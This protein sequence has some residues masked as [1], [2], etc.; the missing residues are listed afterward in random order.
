MYYAFATYLT[1][2]FLISLV[3]NVMI[4]CF[5][6]GEGR[7]ALHWLSFPPLTHELCLQEIL[8]VTGNHKEFE[9]II[10]SLHRYCAYTKGSMIRKFLLI[11]YNCNML[12][13][14]CAKLCSSWLQAYT[15]SD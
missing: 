8:L 13:L 11:N 1:K 7:D 5:L 14:S 4:E 12:G 15:A 3:K 10:K 2:L 9:Q 6:S